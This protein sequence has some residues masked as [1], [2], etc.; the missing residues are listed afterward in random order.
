MAVD[1]Y[2]LQ[3]SVACVDELYQAIKGQII[4]TLLQS[5][6][7]NSQSQ[8]EVNNLEKKHSKVNRRPIPIIKLWR[9]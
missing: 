5:T 1:E 9:C 4:P 2:C 6:E 3:G 7:W 8:F